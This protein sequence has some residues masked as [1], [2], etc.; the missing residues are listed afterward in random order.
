MTWACVS[1]CPHPNTHMYTTLVKGA[2]VLQL[3]FMLV[4]FQFRRASALAP[5]WAQ[6][7]GSSFAVC[8]PR[9]T[10]G[11]CWAPFPCPV[12]QS[13]RRGA[14]SPVQP[15]V[16]SFLTYPTPPTHTFIHTLMHLCTHSHTFTLLLNSSLIS[17]VL[18]FNS[19]T[20]Q[21]EHRPHKLK[22]RFLQRKTTLNCR[23]QTQMGSPG[24]SHFWLGYKHGPLFRFDNLLERSRGLT[25][26]TMLMMTVWL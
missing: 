4:W 9:G 14:L 11:S 18:Q 26:S 24:S 6:G 15:R 19:D 17:T 2:L 7:W 20:T 10:P 25:E 1:S 22:G 12:P 8:L 16:P 3:E 5:A 13:S 21:S 23:C